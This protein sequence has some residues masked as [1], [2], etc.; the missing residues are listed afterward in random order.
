[1]SI[2]TAPLSIAADRA[3]ASIDKTGMQFPVHTF[4]N[5]AKQKKKIPDELSGDHKL[6][7]VAFQR[8]HQQLVDTWFAAGDSLELA[9]NK[10]GKLFR[11]YEIPTI[12]KMGF[13]GRSF[14]NMG[15]RSGVKAQAARERTFTIYIDKAPFKKRLQI[16]NETDIHLFLLNNTGKVLWRCQGKHSPKNEKSLRQFLKK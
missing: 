16:P 11:Y 6:M 5:L 7:I 15:M 8:N 9:Y 14:L 12:Y 1:M 10:P 4:S 3:P 2:L 13:L